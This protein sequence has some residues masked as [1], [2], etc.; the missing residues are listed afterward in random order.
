MSVILNGEIVLLRTTCAEDI[1]DYERWNDPSLKAWETDGPWFDDDLSGLIAGRKKWVESAQLP[2]YRSLEIDAADGTH[3]GWVVVY[4]D[5]TDPHMTEIGIDI[6]EDAYWGK[7]CGKE[8]LELWI[9]YLFRERN[10]TR[11]G[12]STW[13]GNAGMIRLGQKL[14]FVEEARIRNGCEVKCVFYD[15]IKKGILREEWDALKTTSLYRSSGK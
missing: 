5:K 7:G 6:A 14:G 1:A 12:F 2:P 8:S 15:R 9:D 3:I 11:L 10:L 4:Y 13:S